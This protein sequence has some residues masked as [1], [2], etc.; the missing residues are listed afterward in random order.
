MQIS[1]TYYSIYYYIVDESHWYYN[2]SYM[3]DILSLFY[4]KKKLFN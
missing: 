2:L 3:I 4:K 1:V